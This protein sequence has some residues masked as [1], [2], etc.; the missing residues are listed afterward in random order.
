MGGAGAPVRLVLT[1]DPAGR[2]ANIPHD[3]IHEYTCKCPIQ[4]QCGWVRR[5]NFMLNI[6]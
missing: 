6:V 2:Q 5:D 1:A 4:P 3:N